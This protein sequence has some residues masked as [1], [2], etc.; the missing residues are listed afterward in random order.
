M[1]TGEYE[2]EPINLKLYDFSTEQHEREFQ[3][4]YIFFYDEEK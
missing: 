1:K 4:E 3:L 2:Y